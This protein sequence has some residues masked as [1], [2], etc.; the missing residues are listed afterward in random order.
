QTET[1]PILRFILH[2]D[3]ADFDLVSIWSSVAWVRLTTA[4]VENRQQR[5]FLTSMRPA[6]ASLCSSPRVF[7]QI[8]KFQCTPVL[9]RKL[10]SPVCFLTS[11]FS[12]PRSLIPVRG[13]SVLKYTSSRFST[14]DN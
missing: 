12:P 9:E 10:P 14:S 3:F 6:G 8:L 2:M 1:R 13:S 4:L 5:C 7:S 11:S